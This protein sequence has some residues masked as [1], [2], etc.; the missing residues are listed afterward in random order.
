MFAR[1]KSDEKNTFYH[2]P[3]CVNP[4]ICI[5]NAKFKKTK[6]WPHPN[7]IRDQG[8]VLGNTNFCR[9]KQICGFTH[10]QCFFLRF[11]KANVFLQMNGDNTNEKSYLWHVWRE[12]VFMWS[13][14]G[15]MRSRRYREAYSEINRP[16][17][18]LLQNISK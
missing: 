6:T 2:H 10:I 7:I 18:A 11:K 9:G 12:M 17:F 16:F 14:K 1:R 8:H 5:G 3:L 4:Q 15:F 13:E